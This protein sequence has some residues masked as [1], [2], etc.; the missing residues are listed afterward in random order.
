MVG[1]ARYREYHAL[2]KLDIIAFLMEF[3]LFRE[4]QIKKYMHLEFL[5]VISTMKQRNGGHWEKI[6][7]INA[8]FPK[9]ILMIPSSIHVQVTKG[10]RQSRYFGHRIT[11][12]LLDCMKI[13]NYYLIIM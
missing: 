2:I 9:G 4:N 1:M 5:T 8:L 10:L 3:T 11:Q 13:L 7:N 6:R 12:L